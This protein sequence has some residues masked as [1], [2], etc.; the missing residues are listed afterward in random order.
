[1]MMDRAAA[2]IASLALLCLVV[3]PARASVIVGPGFGQADLAGHLQVLRDPD[4]RLDIRAVSGP[5]LEDRFVP[6]SA[7]RGLAGFQRGAVWLRF[8]LGWR[9]GDQQPMW[10]ELGFPH[11]DRVELYAPRDGGGFDAR[12]AGNG[13]PF[14]KREIDHRHVAF[15]LA[16][17][18]GEPRAYYLR[19]ETDASLQLP[20]RLWSEPAFAAVRESSQ[21]L[22]G[23]YYGAM[24]MLLLAV[25]LA[26]VILRAG[27]FLRYFVYMAC[28]V[29]LQVALTG[30]G[31][32]YLWP[33]WA[34][35]EG[36][37]YGVLGGLALAGAFR[38]ASGFLDIDTRVPR[39]R[40]VYL[41]GAGLGL[42]TALAALTLPPAWVNPGLTWLALLAG[43]WLL[44]GA[45]AQ[46]SVQPLARWFL[47]AWGLCLSFVAVGAL[48]YL[49]A[50]PHTPL[51]AH[52]L[53]ISSLV[54]VAVLT[55][56]LVDRLRALREE[57]ERA[58]E[59]AQR[60]LASLNEQLEQVV[61]ERT[62][63]LM[64][65]NQRL[66]E[67][68]NQDSLT[69][70]LNHRTVMETMQ[71]AFSAAT[72][73]GQAMG[74]I[75]IDLDHFKRVNDQYGHLAGDQVLTGV[76][77]VLKS[78]VR[79]SDLCGRFGGEEFLLVLPQASEQ[80]AHELAERLREAIARL[81]IPAL[82]GERV[83]A[84]FGVA[85]YPG[86]G[87]DSPLDMVRRADGALYRAKQGGRNRTVLAPPVATDG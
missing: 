84:S 66:L 7:V 50:L 45:L 74:V 32:Q 86:R 4:G 19:L 41:V 72:R 58:T 81:E 83:T 57:K 75:M 27:L 76:A 70:L 65:S 51:T 2:I 29:L 56:A 60:H 53:Q 36:R 21:L 42:V 37:A 63:T 68:V 9:A 71:R 24:A 54:E 49:G 59:D 40:P 44:S 34:W 25:L 69:G 26:W 11:L 28:Y 67:L 35:W 55:L 33:G 30:H 14:S 6:L 15:R 10:L 12:R 22:L 8:S 39:L 47:L 17:H 18:P 52:A 31:Y 80:A 5:G 82:K 13:L 38:F 3:G 62:Q 85:I 20:L 1:M 43:P 87:D 61:A 16:G 64:D 48:Y 46:A 23:L 79:A 77:R 73:Y 78:G